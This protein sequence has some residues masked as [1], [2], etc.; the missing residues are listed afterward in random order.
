LAGMFR[1]T[2]PAGEGIP[3]K[4]GLRKQTTDGADFREEHGWMFRPC[5]SVPS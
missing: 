4:H 2:I 5:K 3:P 1:R